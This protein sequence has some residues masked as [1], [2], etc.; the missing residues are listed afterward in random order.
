M[1][2]QIRINGQVADLSPGM[3]TGLEL[4]NPYLVYEDILASKASIPALPATRRN[5]QI[6]G[7]P[8][9]LQNEAV[10]MRYRC[11]KYYNGQ[12]LQA[13]VAVLTEA[14]QNFALTVVQP[15]G[16]VFGELQRKN[17]SELNFGALAVPGVLQ[18]TLQQFGRDVV[19]FPTV[20][21][22]TYYGANGAAISYGGR[23]NNYQGGAYTAGPL[24]PMV[25][26]AELLLRIG[27][28]TG[29]A[30]IGE[31]F[32]HPELRQL[33]LYNTRA[34]DGRSQVELRQHLP[35]LTIPELLLELRKTF[36]LAMRVNAIERAIRLDFTDSFHRRAASI[37]W[38]EKALKEYKKRPETA[39]RLQLGSV[40][41]SADGL[42]KDKPESLADY[43]TPELESET[44]IGKLTS[45]FSTL[46]TDPATGLATTQ[47][48]G[49]TEQFGQLASGWSP[50]LLFWN[51]LQ[52]GLPMATARLNG[53]SLYWPGADGLAAR[54]WPM[55]EQHRTRRFYVERQLDLNEVDLAT[56]DF[57]K[58]VHINGLD[59]FVARVD[60]MLPIKKVSNVLLVKS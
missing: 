57:S 8:D 55:T 39:R 3:S 5:R 13:G 14:A 33:L 19:A 45:R 38:S 29:V 50:R 16:E 42:T 25:F 23:M 34:L 44:G 59:Y 7:F 10:G 21:N 47:Q 31:F 30:F 2:L 56:L 43:L 51:G 32:S 53:Y 11:E 6:L 58:K 28:L 17:L 18:P 22:P 49:R 9:L 36:N 54:F 20:L 48:A 27:E 46:L 12:L 37:D 60:L 41:D 4:I 40:A 24:V 1:S 35:E 52:S 15:L 26:V